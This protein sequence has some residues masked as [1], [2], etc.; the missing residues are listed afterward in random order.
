MK[1]ID[2]H[3][4]TIP[5]DLDADFNFNIEKLKQYVINCSLDAIAITNHNLFDEKQYSDIS[6]NIK[7]IVF[8]GIEVSLEH[9]HLLIIS[10]SNNLNE[11]VTISK[12]LHEEYL[13]NKSISND[14]LRKIIPNMEKYLLIPH[15]Q[16][17]PTV[18]KK[19]L[20]SFNDVLYC[21][22]VTSPK[23]FEVC[24]NNDS[25]LTP[26]LFSDFRKYNKDDVF[27]TKQTFM[28]IGEISL[29]SIKNC[30]IA[31]KV[32]LNS[33][34]ETKIFS[35]ANGKV[36]ASTGLNVILGKRSSGKTYM[37]NCIAEDYSSNNIKYIKQF[38]LVSKS[39]DDIFSQIVQR[40]NDAQ[41]EE[42][43]QPLKKIVDL[44]INVDLDNDGSKIDIY[45]KSLKEYAFNIEKEDIYSKTKL[46]NENQFEIDNFNNLKIIITGLISLLDSKEYMS[47]A[48]Q[49]IDVNMLPH[50]ILDF[51]NEY[52]EK[53]LT[54][55]L[56]EETNK[57]ISD[58]RELLGKKSSLKPIEQFSIS[59]VFK[60]I[61]YVQNFNLLIELISREK[62]ISS[63]KDNGFKL[64]TTIKRISSAKELN[65][66]LGTKNTGNIIKEKNPYKYL[67]MLKEQKDIIQLDISQ[68][69]KAFWKVTFEVLNEFDA[70]LSGGEK[71]EYNLIAELKDSYKYDVVLIDELESS[72]DNP[73]LNDNVVSLIHDISKKS[74]VFIVTHNNTLGVLLKPD[75]LIYTYKY[76]V[77]NE[78][79]Y[80][81]YSCKFGDSEMKTE[82]GKVFKTYDI[83]MET[84][85][86]NENAYKE[87]KLIYENFKN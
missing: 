22:E 84:M 62:I 20:R 32:A 18:S 83:L 14:M 82:N 53:S 73:F 11:F 19:F 80:E 7:C 66:E 61:L 58:I 85:E 74:T 59:S 44:V 12:Q 1:K 38:D 70:P 35:I 16:K 33:E 69:Y 77:D 28:D 63:N 72:F 9:G 29:K 47:I 41:K 8:P 64:N 36:K 17:E 26:L 42:I 87:R 3:I 5:T 6:N 27:P 60:S 54:N 2:L 37:V 25:M 13:I 21:G 49:Y 48:E 40:E 50:L 71:S 30:L 52:Y 4:H 34:N 31:R 65:K 68:L 57:L 86:A 10:D 24:L 51:I 79:F 39:E 56:K 23:K 55:Y 46:F 45:L 78:S 15:Y 67:T 43:L 75:V 76:K 81:L